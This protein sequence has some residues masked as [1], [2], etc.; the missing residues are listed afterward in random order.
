MHRTEGGELKTTRCLG[1]QCFFTS[2][3]DVGACYVVPLLL[4]AG[5][6]QEVSRSAAISAMGVRI[7]SSLIFMKP[8]VS[9]E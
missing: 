2:L 6:G 4:R 8:S 7:F 1:A 9:L 5:R 3:N